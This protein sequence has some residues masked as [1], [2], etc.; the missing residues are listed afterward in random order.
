MKSFVLLCLLASTA[1]ADTNTLWAYMPEGAAV[2]LV[3]PVAEV[4]RVYPPYQA[5]E[6]CG[7]TTSNPAP[8]WYKVV[9]DTAPEGERITATGWLLTNDFLHQTVVATVNIAEEEAAKAAEAEAAA[10]MAA[11][12]K[13]ARIAALAASEVGNQVMLLRAK[14]LSLGYEPPFE[15]TTIA[16]DLLG[17]F[18]AGTLTEA[19]QIDM[20]SAMT[21]YR[22]LHDMALTDEEL[23]DVREY[24]EA[25][26]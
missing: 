13:A 17:R 18:A 25:Q 16:P 8:G 11:A 2:P 6:T 15:F 23:R 20:L 14:L 9:V 1:V 24:L 21:V 26:N 10:A 4:D 3:G 12:T 5:G 22:M 7:Y 19:Q